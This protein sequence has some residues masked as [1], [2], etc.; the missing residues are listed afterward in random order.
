MSYLVEH[1]KQ[2]CSQSQT[3]KIACVYY[4]FYYGHDQDEAGPFL[5]WL[6]NQL[7]RQADLVPSSVYEMY[8]Y[9]GTPS[10]VE[11]LQALEGILDSFE[12][13]YVIVDAIDES[14][15]RKDLLKVLRDLATDPRFKKLQLLASSREYI[16]IEKVMEEFSVS[17]SM[18]NPF[19]EEDIR[20]HIHSALQS[21]PKFRRWPQEILDEVEAAVSKGAE[22]MYFTVLPPR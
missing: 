16:D 21:D 7:C 5:Q 8:K 13:T 11:L 4:Y 14:K 17:V 3:G 19:V 9:G 15:P 6:L 2:H 20:L 10:L 12:I 1:I 18:A 22:G